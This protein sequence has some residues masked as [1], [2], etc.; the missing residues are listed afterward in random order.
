[1]A[2]IVFK[3]AQMMD[4]ANIIRDLASSYK[5]AGASFENEFL[6]ATTEWKG[7]SKDKMRLFITGTVGEYTQNTVPQLL[8]SLAAL[9]EANAKQMETADQQ[10]AEHIPG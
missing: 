8:T 9:L 4:T 3:Y 1:M 6:S 10:L 7:A 5:D 2:D